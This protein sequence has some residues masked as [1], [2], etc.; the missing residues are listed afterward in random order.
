MENFIVLFIVGAAGLWGAFHL[1]RKRKATS[2]GSG[3]GGC[4]CPNK[5]SSPSTLVTLRR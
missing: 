4:S 2:C 5:A 1:L 3:C